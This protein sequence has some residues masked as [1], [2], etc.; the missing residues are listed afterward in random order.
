MYQK[1]LKF[2]LCYQNSV[3]SSVILWCHFLWLGLVW[4]VTGGLFWVNAVFQGLAL[5]ITFT[6]NCS[7]FSC[8][9]LLFFFFLHQGGGFEWD[10][11]FSSPEPSF[12][13]KAANSLISSKPPLQS[14]YFSPPPPARTLD[15][16]WSHS[17]PYSRF[18]ISP[19]NM[20]SFSLTHLTDSDIEQGGKWF[21]YSYYFE[22]MN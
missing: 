2:R 20:A 1:P 5:K 19:A 14:K 22:A 17:S 6:V 11:D 18:S 4:K 9:L 15:Q 16:N 10:D 8:F 21:S 3:A 13:S 7:F 12:I